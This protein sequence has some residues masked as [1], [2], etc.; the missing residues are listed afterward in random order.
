MPP[1]VAAPA[2]VP[3]GNLFSFNFITIL[4]SKGIGAG[5]TTR[6]STPASDRLIEA[7]AAA[8]SKAHRAQL[9]RRSQALMQSEAPLIPLLFLPSRVAADSRLT[10]LRVIS[11]KPGYSMNT[12][13]RTLAPILTP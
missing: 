13:E 5:N 4:H 11:L 3:K 8:D 12:V 6:F 7:I 2:L 1:R 10:G 9:L